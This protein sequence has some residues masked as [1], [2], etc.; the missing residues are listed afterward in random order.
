MEFREELNDLSKIPALVSGEPGL[1][2]QTYPTVLAL[3]KGHDSDPL[4]PGNACLPSFC[5]TTSP[6]SAR[7]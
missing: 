4:P 1:T 6:I 7:V 5:L 2:Q 3:S